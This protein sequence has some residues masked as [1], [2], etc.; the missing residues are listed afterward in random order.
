MIARLIALRDCE[1]GASLIEFAMVAPF[2]AALVLGIIDLSKAYSDRLELE[3]AAQSTIEKLEQQH[4]VATDYS[5][6]KA[7]AAARAGITPTASNPTVTQWLECS[8]DNGATWTSQGNN[9]LANECPNGTDLPARY[10][11]ITVSKTY[12]PIIGMPYIANNANGTYTLTARAGL[13]IQ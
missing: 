9:S 6:L 10:V 3:Q 5:S 11:T 1:S 13:R 8:S 4:T 7:E 2:L 12:S